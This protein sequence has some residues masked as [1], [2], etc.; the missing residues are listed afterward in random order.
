ML[1]RWKRAAF[2]A[3]ALGLVTTGYFL[4]TR[5]DTATTMVARATAI[6]PEAAMWATP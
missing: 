5:P 4:P 6:S 1:A 2:Y 3:I